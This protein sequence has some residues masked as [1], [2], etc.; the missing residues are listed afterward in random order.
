MTALSDGERGLL[1]PALQGGRRG[2]GRV[3]GGDLPERSSTEAWGTSGGLRD[4]AK[5]T[6]TGALNA[7]EDKRVL[8]ICVLHGTWHSVMLRIGA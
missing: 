3:W 2:L 7:L 5:D 1:C 6:C 8:C 4:G